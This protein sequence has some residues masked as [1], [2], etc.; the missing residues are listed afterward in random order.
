MSLV[1]YV[2]HFFFLTLVLNSAN[3]QSCF[4]EI[5]ERELPIE[6]YTSPDSDE[7][8]ELLGNLYCFIGE[9][10]D[11]I[12]IEIFSYDG[13][14]VAVIFKNIQSD[15]F[16][17]TY[18]GLKQFMIAESKDPSY[19]KM[20]D[21]H[22]LT[23]DFSE[24]PAIYENW[25]TDKQAL[26]N[27]GIP[28]D[29]L[30]PFEEY[31]KIHSDSSKTYEQLM[32]EFELS[33]Q[34]SNS[35]EKE[36]LEVSSEELRKELLESKVVHQIDAF[37]KRSKRENKPVLMYFTGFNVTSSRKLEY[38]IFNDATILNHLKNDV[39]FLS[40]YVD[41]KRALPKEH[42]KYS[43]TLD[44]TIETYGDANIA[45]EIELTGIASQPYFVALSDTGKVIGTGTYQDFKSPEDFRA[46]LNSV[47][48][49]FEK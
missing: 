48:S 6:T 18:S 15:A 26:L 12:D 42:Q 10:L 40:L 37:A 32:K 47:Q 21:L 46:F 28:N 44:R 30:Q 3:S 35:T 49:K 20:R 36:T 27:L 43:E 1:R 16:P 11:T 4:E 9:D 41:D 22:I 19:S 38:F 14:L 39:I 5:S 8:S 25:D 45:M 31:L 34:Q 33:K 23:R 7:F 29:K 17:L 2:L 24:L 13:Y